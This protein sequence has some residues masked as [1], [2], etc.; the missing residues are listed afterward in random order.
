VGWAIKEI[1][2]DLCQRVYGVTPGKDK[3]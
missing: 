3:I 2:T 1:M